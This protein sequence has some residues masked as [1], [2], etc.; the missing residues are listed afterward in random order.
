MQEH[1]VHELR[2]IEV[3]F[4]GLVERVGGGRRLADHDVVNGRVTRAH[5]AL[6]DHVVV[7]LCAA[8]IRFAKA[9]DRLLGKVIGAPLEPVDEEMKEAVMAGH[10]THRVKGVFHKRIADA[11]AARALVGA[12]HIGRVVAPVPP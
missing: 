2:Q 3:A 9:I 10:A 11:H 12:V 6:M 7:R 8:E 4:H 1:V 5:I